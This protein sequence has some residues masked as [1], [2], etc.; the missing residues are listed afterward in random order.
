MAHPAQL[1]EQAKI[2]V[3]TLNSGLTFAAGIENPHSPRQWTANFIE[4][5]CGKSAW[6]SAMIYPP[7]LFPEPNPR[8][9]FLAFCVCPDTI[10]G[11]P[12]HWRN[13]KH[14]RHP[15]NKVPPTQQ[16][17]IILFCSRILMPLRSSHQLTLTTF[18]H[19]SRYLST[20]SCRAFLNSI[21]N[22]ESQPFKR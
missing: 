12:C 6:K 8:F 15:Y 3:G 16:N 17:R 13:F 21:F 22:P 18:A 1:I 5:W 9:S 19:V 7:A 4:T 11:E 2:Q 14:W 20:Y 10:A